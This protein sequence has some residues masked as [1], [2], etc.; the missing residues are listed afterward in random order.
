M[1]ACSIQNGCSWCC[2]NVLFAPS[3][4]GGRDVAFAGI[5]DSYAKCAQ[6]SECSSDMWKTVEKQ[7]SVALVAVESATRS[8]TFDTLT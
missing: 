4:A 3:E 6:A 8:L 7:I 1:N 2:R 5:R